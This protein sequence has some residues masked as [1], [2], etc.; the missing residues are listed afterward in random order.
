MKCLQLVTDVIFPE[1][2]EPWAHVELWAVHFGCTNV[3]F[4][5]CHAQRT[6]PSICGLQKSLKSPGFDFTQKEFPPV[7][8]SSRS[9]LD[10]HDFKRIDLDHFFF[11][12]RFHFFFF[13]TL[14]KREGGV[15]TMEEKIYE[16]PPTEG[17]KNEDVGAAVYLVDLRYL[18]FAESR[19][20]ER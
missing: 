10:R 16:I 18:S 17:K 19:V 2:R 11:R 15:F 12:S 1:G 13:S 14:L 20:V 5:V 8:F 7:S 4:S 3:L 9:A 6:K